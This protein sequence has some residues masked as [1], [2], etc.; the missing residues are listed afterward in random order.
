MRNAFFNN[1]EEPQFNLTI[2]MK[3]RVNRRVTPKIQNAMPARENPVPGKNDPEP[4]PSQ[5]PPGLPI[6]KKKEMYEIVM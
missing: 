2:M 1:P 6:R 4:E 5:Q 3:Q